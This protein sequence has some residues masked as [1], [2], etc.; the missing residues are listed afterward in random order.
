MA[1]RTK[2][3]LLAIVN[4]LIGDRND[5]ESLTILEDFS[6]TFKSFDEVDAAEWQ[7]RLDAK[8]A[9]WRERYRNRFFASDPIVE[10]EEEEEKETKTID[11]LFE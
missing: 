4:S 2:Y 1:I 5:E 8:E 10:E 7:A 9:E 3:E 6:D 11:D